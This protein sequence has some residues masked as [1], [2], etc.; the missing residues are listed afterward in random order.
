VPLVI[1]A[2]QIQDDP[3]HTNHEAFHELNISGLT[4]AITKDALKINNIEGIQ[5]AL[6]NSLTMTTNGRPGPVLLE[7]TTDTTMTVNRTTV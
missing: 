2:G 5:E 3:L 4:M 6:K 1:I 7:L